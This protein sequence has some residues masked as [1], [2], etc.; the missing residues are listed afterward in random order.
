MAFNYP[1]RMSVRPKIMSAMQRVAREHE[2]VLAPLSDDLVLFE[3]GLD[4]LCLAVLVARLEDELMV[5]PFSDATS[6][7]FP[8][9]VSD[10]V[11]AYEHAVETV[12]GGRGR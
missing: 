9:T 12:A 6:A 7:D 11:T 2:R 8:V 4:S 3:S 10:L 1:Y 5:D